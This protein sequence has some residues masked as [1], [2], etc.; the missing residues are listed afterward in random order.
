MSKFSGFSPSI[1][2]FLAELEQNNDKEWFSANRDRYEAEVRGPAFA[3]IEA[4][5]ASIDKI[6]PHFRVEA[7]KVGGSLMRI[8][9]DIRFSKDKSPYKTNVG[10]QFRHTSGCDAHAPGF[11]LHISPEESFFGVGTWHPAG[12]LL[13]AIRKWIDK[14]PKDWKKSISP[15]SFRDRFELVG[16]S[17]K[18]APKGFDSEHPL[19]VDLRRKDFIAVQNLDQGD[20]SSKEF[21]KESAAAFRSAKPFMNFLCQA[22]NVPF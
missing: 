17:L 22:I 11:Y 15:K 4:M 18:R 16:D 13:H 20:V 19:I 3:Y 14:H 8:H 1:Y 2:Q 21:I 5:K 7:K 9:R 10:I 12:G 6:S